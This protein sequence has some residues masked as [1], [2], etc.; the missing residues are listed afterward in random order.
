MKI[1]FKKL[2]LITCI[3]LIFSLISI[4]AIFR[5]QEKNTNIAENQQESTQQI[6]RDSKPE[7]EIKIQVPESYDIKIPFISQAPFGVWDELHDDACEEA[8]LL[9]IHYYLQNINPS[10]NQMDLDIRALVDYQIE[11]YGKHKD[12]TSKE[13][14]DLAHEYLKYQ[15]VRIVYDF[16]WGDLKKEISQNKPVIIP[17]VG[18][19]LNNPYFTAPGPI[20]HMLVIR[21]YNQT[22]LITNDVGT[23]RGEAYTYTYDVLDDAIHDWTGDYDTIL[24]GRRAYIVIN[25]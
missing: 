18:R 19:L 17:A 25:G 12:L 16:T 5:S 6:I 22:H 1:S 4:W 2:P 20:Y 11:K 23:R 3:V 15:D 21:G 7:G 13:V 8:S 9:L 24:S 14:V 10:K